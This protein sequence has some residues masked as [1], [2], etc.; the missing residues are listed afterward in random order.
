MS[1]KRTN[2]R[3]TKRLKNKS[4]IKAIR[5]SGGTLVRDGKG[6]HGIPQSTVGE[7]KMLPRAVR[8]RQERLNA[9]ID[10]HNPAPANKPP[11]AGQ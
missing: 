8:R 2:R 4:G 5:K 6:G 7:L 3:G 9:K 1:K 11:P 10:K